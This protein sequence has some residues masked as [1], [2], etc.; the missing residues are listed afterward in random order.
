VRLL[1]SSS[2]LSWRETHILSTVVSAILFHF[3]EEEISIYISFA[4]TLLTS[5]GLIAWLWNERQG[6]MATTKY[7]YGPSFQTV[8]S[9]TLPQ[10]ILGFVHI[11]VRAGVQFFSVALI[12]AW[13]SFTVRRFLAGLLVGFD[14]NVIATGSGATADHACRLRAG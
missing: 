13:L 1:S 14:A 6:A 10:I 5:S 12:A 11:G 7:N 9:A 2:Q 3:R 8:I 4:T